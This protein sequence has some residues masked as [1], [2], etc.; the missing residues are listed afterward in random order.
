[1][2]N[3]LPDNGL[4]GPPGRAGFW[5]IAVL[6]GLA[7]RLALLPLGPGFG[8]FPDHDDF[9][10][11]GIQAADRGLASLYVSPP[12]RADARTFDPKTREWRITRRDYDR[13]CNYP[14]L[15]AMLFAA[16]GRAFQAL[17]TDRLIN[18]PLAWYL[19]QCWSVL[20]DLVAAAGGAAL[21]AALRPGSQRA[22][23]LLLLFAPPFVWDSAVW[24]QTDA[25]LLAHALWMVRAMTRRRWK[26]AGALL[27]IAA[28]FKP[29]AVLLVPLWAL[30]LLCRRERRQVAVGL[31]VA[32]LVLFVVS[33]PFTLHSGDAW[34]RRSY[35]E[36]LF[37]AH[38]AQT[39][40]VAFNL[41]YLDLL[42]TGSDNAHAP[43]FGLSR[44]AWGALLLAA[45]LAAGLVWSFRRR[46][47]DADRLVAWAG[48]SLLACVMLPTRVHER[49]L[50]LPLAFLLVAA[51]NRRRLRAGA[52]LMLLV[53][54]AQVT[55]PLWMKAD[56]GL[57]HEI[58]EQ[59]EQQ[60]AV[61]LQALP[62]D[63]RLLVPPFEDLLK[64]HRARF[65]RERAQTIPFEWGCT[66]VALL[67][68]ALTVRGL[69]RPRES[70]AGPASR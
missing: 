11:W 25:L 28:G 37:E 56:A 66:I 58:R 48:L 26:L 60:Y 21:A 15:T 53:A 22:A 14:P 36:N 3:L 32:P 12:P 33:L 43:L 30:A 47:N 2:S 59:L 27:G 23:F 41:W 44:N 63:Q 4:P 31:A 6:A 18:T 69:V 17:S 5:P 52:M 16:S 24:G 45:A 51:F 65:E 54:S 10:R 34:F 20:A 1:M 35:V 68:T 70:R 62:P 7:L 49:Y 50:L 64:P 39:T 38:R 29:Q 9:T 67:G 42:R 40:L 13:V 8:Y 19:V 55:W 57:W 61:R 46:T